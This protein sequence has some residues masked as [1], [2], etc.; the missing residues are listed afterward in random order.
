M[1]RTRHDLFWT[2]SGSRKS[3]TRSCVGEQSA[4]RGLVAARRRTC[5][6]RRM[7]AASHY[8][9]STTVRE[10]RRPPAAAGGRGEHRRIVRRL[11][12]LF[13]VRSIAMIGHRD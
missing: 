1:R 9:K 5:C 7:T 8:L 2:S 6:L 10:A 3:A 11:G 13:T 4:A 12:E